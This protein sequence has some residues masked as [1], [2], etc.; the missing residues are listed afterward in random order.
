M[1]SVT[2]FSLYTVC[3][4]IETIERVLSITVIYKGSKITYASEDLQIN[5]ISKSPYKYTKQCLIY[6]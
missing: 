6:M 4:A 2:N 3:I 5:S 1:L